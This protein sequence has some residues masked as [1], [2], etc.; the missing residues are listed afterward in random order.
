MQIQ[1]PGCSKVVDVP[2]G[3]AGQVVA[4]PECG[5]QMQVPA[6]E[7][8]ADASLSVAEGS[9]EPTKQCPYCGET[10]LAVARRC[11]HCKEEI[12][13]G[14]DVESIRKR[15]AAKEEAL[16][17]QL[18]S[19]GMPEIPWGVGGKFRIRTIVGAVLTVVG[20]IVGAAMIAFG[21][22]DV[23]PFAFVPITTA[24]IAVICTL[25]AFLNDMKTPCASAR[26]TP[27]AGIKAFLQSLRVGRFD[28]AY[29]CLLSSDKDSTERRRKAFE[30]L[31]VKAGTFSFA[32]LSGFKAYWKNLTRTSGGCTRR[33]AVSSFSVEKEE[34]DW[35]LVRVSAKLQAYPSAI[36]IAVIFG[37]PGIVI[38]CIL[39]AVMTKRET[40]EITKLLRKVNGQWYVVNGELESAE[41]R[42]IN[43]AVE[44]AAK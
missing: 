28:Y 40:V 32:E 23:A 3:S 42:A 37:L 4:C 31:K 14:G 39:I 11:K 27:V 6:A 16:A 41:D 25:V 8:A 43:V 29:A 2:D 12:S 44:L 24:V 19:G 9:A 35:A 30:D 36:V 10:V 38:A 1:C 33:M 17:K 18:A 5:G 34:G 13:A 21:D 26:T 22:N 20:V 15:L 7:P